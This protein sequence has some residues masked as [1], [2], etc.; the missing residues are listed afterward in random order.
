MHPCSE[1]RTIALEC[2]RLVIQNQNLNSADNIVTEARV[3]FDFII[4]DA[5]RASQS[6]PGDA[7]I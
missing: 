7:P 3:L 1:E 5:G 2:V 6:K 4:A